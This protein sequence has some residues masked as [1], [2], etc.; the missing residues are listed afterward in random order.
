M[1]ND[2]CEVSNMQLCSNLCSML[3]CANFMPAI[4]KLSFVKKVTVRRVKFKGDYGSRFFKMS[5]C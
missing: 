2:K 5:I 1:N 3:T 4:C